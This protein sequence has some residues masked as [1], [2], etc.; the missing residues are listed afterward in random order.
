[1]IDAPTYIRPHESQKIPFKY[2]LWLELIFF[3]KNVFALHIIRYP[4]SITHS[5]KLVLPGH[6]VLKLACINVRI[7]RTQY[8]GASVVDKISDVAKVKSELACSLWTLDR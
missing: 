3:N 6:K 5:V 4:D 2:K 1:M 8:V 7:D